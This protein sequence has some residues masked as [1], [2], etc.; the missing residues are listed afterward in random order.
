MILIEG[1]WDS[2][3]FMK[4][5]CFSIK[6]P[7]HVCEGI[8]AFRNFVVNVLLGCQ[9]LDFIQGNQQNFQTTCTSKHFPK[10]DQNKKKL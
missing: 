6:F 7:P 3:P 5:N 4:I 2:F 10:T 8:F 9:M 1:K